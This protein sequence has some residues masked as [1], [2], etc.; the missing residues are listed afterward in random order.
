MGVAGEQY[1]N[2]H[3]RTFRAEKFDLTAE[4]RLA[5]GQR[6][7]H[8][9][10]RLLEDAGG[11]FFGGVFF[12]HLGRIEILRR[13]HAERFGAQEIGDRH[14]HHHLAHRAHTLHRA[15]GELVRRHRVAEIVELL[16]GAIEVGQ[17]DVGIIGRLG[18]AQGGE[19]QKQGE[20]EQLLLH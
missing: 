8:G 12:L 19:H 5:G 20:N 13:G 16:R 1:K 3:A 14:V 6:F 2:R 9:L 18:L 7:A 15:V 10:L 17:E 4:I 11:V